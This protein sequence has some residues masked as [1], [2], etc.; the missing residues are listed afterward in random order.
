MIWSAHSLV[1]ATLVVS[2]CDGSTVTLLYDNVLPLPVVQYTYIV[3][4]GL[5]TDTPAMDSQS[6]TMSAE[7]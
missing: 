7:E 5:L 2:R 6:V 4:N 1:N 3:I